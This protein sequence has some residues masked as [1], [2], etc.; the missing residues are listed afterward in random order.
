QV[1]V[2]GRLVGDDCVVVARREAG[3]QHVAEVERD[4]VGAAAFVCQP[5]G[6]ADL[7][8]RDRH[9]VDEAAE[10]V[11]QHERRSPTPGTGIEYPATGP[12]VAQGVQD[13]LRLPV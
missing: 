13:Q 12:D 1:D 9:A 2:H 5:G 6:E 4:V 11:V 7:V 3:A 8:R 10:A